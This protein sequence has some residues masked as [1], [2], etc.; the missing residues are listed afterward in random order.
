[1]LRYAGVVVKAGSKRLAP[2]GNLY[3]PFGRICCHWFF[4]LRLSIVGL[5]LSRFDI[6]LLVR[7]LRIYLIYRPTFC[8]SSISKNLHPLGN[9]LKYE[10]N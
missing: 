4:P 2:F 6:R 8:H 3:T 1:M 7:A 5:C 10:T 9:A